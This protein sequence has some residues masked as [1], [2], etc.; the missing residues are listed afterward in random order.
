[1]GDVD[2][3]R[4]QWKQLTARGLQPG[5]LP[6]GCMA[7]ALALGGQPDEALELIHS[8]ANSE[9]AKP[10]INPVLTPPFPKLHHGQTCQG[11]LQR[12]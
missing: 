12:E 11:D 5:P 8:H 4:E 3:V 6:F 10:C 1:M 2:R 7:E 9:E